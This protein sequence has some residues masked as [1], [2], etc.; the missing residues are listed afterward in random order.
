MKSVSPLTLS[1][2]T[3]TTRAV[4]QGWLSD[5][6]REPSNPEFSLFKCYLW[7]LDSAVPFDFRGC[8]FSPCHV[9]SGLP[10]TG[11]IFGPLEGFVRTKV[12]YLPPFPFPCVFLGHHNHLWH[13]PTLQHRKSYPANGNFGV[14]GIDC[15]MCYTIA[16]LQL[17]KVAKNTWKCS[18]NQRRQNFVK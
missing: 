1:R 8:S 12:F 15:E 5:R 13:W 16:G 7:F 2:Q 11:G 6:V 3:H 10:S 18:V 17:T 4:V 14:Y 9:W